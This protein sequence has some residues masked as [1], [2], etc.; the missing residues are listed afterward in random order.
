[1][2]QY[3]TVTFPIG[4]VFKTRGKNPRVCTVV[5]ILKTYNSANELVRI[6]YV[7]THTLMGKTVTDHDVCRTT[8]AMGI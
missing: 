3:E 5:D 7:A 4:T 8:I 6:R 2:T 1:M